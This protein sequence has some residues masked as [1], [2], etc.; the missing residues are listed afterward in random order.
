MRYN[1]ITFKLLVVMVTIFIMMMTGIFILE[2]IKVKK[3]LDRSQESEFAER[4]E[5]IFGVLERSN[6]R[7]KRTLREETYLDDFQ[8]SALN[9]LRTNYYSRPEQQIYP[10]ILDAEG[11]VILH[12]LL[13][14]GDPSLAGNWKN[15]ERRAP[16]DPA[17]SYYIYQDDTSWCIFKPFTHWGWEI[18]YHV[19]IEIFYRDIRNLRNNLL[20]IMFGATLLMLLLSAWAVSR[21]TR[22][23]KKLTHASRKIAAG[24]LDQQFDLT[25]NDEVGVLARSF[26]NMREAVKNQISELNH[27]IGERKRAEQAHQETSRMLRLVLDYIPIR[28]YWKDTRSRYL[29]GN[30]SFAEDTGHT[31]P[32]DIIGCT[33]F[34]LPWTRSEAIICRDR[35]KKV[36]ASGVPLLNIEEAFTYESGDIHWLQTNKVPMKGAD[37]TVIGILG[38]YLDITARKHASEELHRLRHTLSAILDSMSS[39]LIGASADTKVIHWNRQAQLATGIAYEEMAGCLLDQALEIFSIDMRLVCKAI[40]SGKELTRPKHSRVKDGKTIFEDITVYPM[41]VEGIEGGVVIRI[42]DITER[43]HLEEVMI[44]NEKMLSVGGLAAG[45]AHEINNP[46]GGMILTSRVL[47]NRLG[48]ELDLPANRKA[49]EE[50]GI[51]M[52]GLKQ[53]MET[54]DIHAM[55][56]SLTQSGKRLTD[57]INNMLGFARKSDTVITTCSLEQLLDR[58]IALANADFNLQKKYDFKKIEIVRNYSGKLPPVSCEEGKIQQVLFNILKNG[59]QAMQVAD[60]ENPRITVRTV[61]DYDRQMACVEIEDNG[62][63]IDE[64]IRKRIFEPF[65]TTKP[66]GEGTG[67]GLSVSYFIITENHGGKISVESELGRFT[68]FHIKLPLQPVD[69]I[70]H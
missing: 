49:A 43:V 28:V 27:E 33:D 3:I 58:T 19:P 37:G 6:D 64:N 25:G 14:E 45:M 59:A 41:T 7:L 21:F 24:N 22:P 8:N 20:V 39:I 66:V 51:T 44:Q 13:P 10:F 56:D 35:D 69:S 48:Q 5:T 70:S 60:T 47:S 2:N 54:R 50:A 16:L 52:E 36:M 15:A 53:F 40:E 32:D 31:S 57:I 38:T 67:L 17:P 23:I 1:S 63:G 12:P 42:D 4:I 11:N 65:F 29:G 62:P 55:L 34:D 30:R 61:F 68:R 18:G 46:L 9:F 26:D